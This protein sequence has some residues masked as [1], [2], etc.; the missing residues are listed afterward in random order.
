LPLAPRHDIC[1]APRTASVRN[2]MNSS[3]FAA[4]AALK[5]NE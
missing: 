2:N 5:R 4:L 1:A 3:A